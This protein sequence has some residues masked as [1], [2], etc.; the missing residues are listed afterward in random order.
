M[1]AVLG[2]H[3]AQK[4]NRLMREIGRSGLFV[5]GFV[6]FLLAATIILPFMGLLFGAGWVTG[7]NLVRP[8]AVSVLGGLLSAI[9]IVGGATSGILG[10]VKQLA[11]E[12]YRTYPVKRR[13]LLVAELVATT[14]DLLPLVLGLG[15]AVTLFGTAW[16]R[17]QLIPLLVPIW[18]ENVLILLLMQLLIGS[19]A[20]RL[21]RRLRTGMIALGLALWVGTALS[22][23]LPQELR[24]GGDPWSHAKLVAITRIGAAAKKF[25]DLLPATFTVRGLSDAAKDHW[26]SGAAT[27]IYPLL[28]IAWLAIVVA[29]M[30]S[31]DADR[32]LEGD[33]ARAGRL[34][35]FRGPVGGVA[36]LQIATILG[37]RVGQF[38]F[39][40]P[41]I[42]VVL[43]RGPL[44]NATGREL[45][46]VPAAFTYLSLVG[47]QFQLNQFGLDG[48][49]VKS[50]LLLPI[51][52]ADL[53]R[54]KTRGLALYQGTQALV[55]VVLLAVMHRP[56][57]L[58]MLSGLLLW[59]CVFTVQNMVGRFT[60]IWMP[61]ML[62]RNAVRGDA[63]P[64]ALVLVGLGL[65]TFCG[66]VFGSIW[67]A[68]VVWS[69]GLLLPVLAA[70]F[71]L[72]AALHRALLGPAARVFR[73]HRERLLAAVG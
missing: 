72:C 13:T 61:R 62:P 19:L 43:I 37:S 31:R 68:C 48:H 70:V 4:R 11:W 14:L 3:L 16:A 24:Q 47:N 28:F 44:A 63:T 56:L 51:S 64:V 33:P 20:E 22:A 21:V 18:I 10:G 8:K 23:S 12:S 49:G 73:R 38:G 25:V 32:S 7:V 39:I 41:L 36:R 60:S 45:W 17:P 9:A 42:V 35:T 30:L 53:F 26:L 69:P 2:A 57:P 52:E 29:R 27:H 67:A 71:A 15:L 34:W 50:L 59:G 5:V 46:A 1:R 58:Q 54:G 40:V 55:L 65:S 6:I 66:G